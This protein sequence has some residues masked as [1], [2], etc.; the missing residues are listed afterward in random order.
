VLS[1]ILVINDYTLNTNVY[2]VERRLSALIG[3]EGGANNQTTIE[4]FKIKLKTNLLD[5]MLNTICI[6]NIKYKNI[7]MLCVYLK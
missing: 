1:I 4:H 5:I 6:H 7:C 3:I 2:T